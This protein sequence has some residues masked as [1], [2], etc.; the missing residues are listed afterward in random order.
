MRIVVISDTHKK[1]L[2]LEYIISKENKADLFIHLGDG[3]NEAS[4]FAEVLKDKFIF[5]RG[6]NDFASIYPSE[7]EI[8]AE[9]KRIFFTHGH[10]Y[11]VKYGFDRI[12]AKAK[13]NKA[14]ILLFGHT[15]QAMRDYQ[16]GLYIMNPGSAG[17]YSQGAPSYGVVEI[18]RA[19][20]VLTI[21]NFK[22]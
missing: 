8:I 12:I 14:D 2:N 1:Y 22:I 15:H 7:G 6:N 3:E 9:G 18:S 4:Q 11:Q 20:V 5:V 17:L 13:S 16:D 10:N 21:V 19:G